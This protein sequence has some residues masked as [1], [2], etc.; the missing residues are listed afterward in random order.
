MVLMRP[1]CGNGPDGSHPFM[2]VNATGRRSVQS[3]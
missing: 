1:G 3:G 2:D